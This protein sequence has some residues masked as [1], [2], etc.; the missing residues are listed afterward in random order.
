MKD[1]ATSGWRFSPYLVSVFVDGALGAKPLAETIEN[2]LGPQR[3]ISFPVVAQL[4]C[5]RTFCPPSRIDLPRF[6]NGC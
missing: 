6:E 4:R 1:I 2:A 3:R 5:A